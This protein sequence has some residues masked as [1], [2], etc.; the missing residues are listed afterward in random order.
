M[1]ADLQE[2]R[3]RDATIEDTEAIGLVAYNAWIFAYA[4]F[5]PADFVA[6][7]ADPVE[8]ARRMRENWRE[9]V[10]QI[11]AISDSGDVIGFAFEH[12]PCTLPGFDAEIGALYVDPASS[13]VGVGRGLVEELVRRFILDGRNSMAIHTLVEN[14]IGCAFYEKLGGQEDLLTT[15]NDFPSKWYVWHDLKES[16]VR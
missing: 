9:D 16:F 2:L 4:G 3:I 10:H 6:A 8:R 15:W 11:V 5:L 1:T 12:R 14:A 7:R 13:R